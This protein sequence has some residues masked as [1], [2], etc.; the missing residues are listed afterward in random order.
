MKAPFEPFS[1]KWRRIVMTAKP[2]VRESGHRKAASEFA[3][4]EARLRAEKNATALQG[5][6]GKIYRKK[7]DFCQIAKASGKVL[8]KRSADKPLIK[9]QII[10]LLSGGIVFALQGS[11][12]SVR[13]VWKR[14]WTYS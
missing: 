9:R 1:G 3:R 5:R 7:G 12:Q 2:N 8:I 11:V 10:D 4:R 14:N 13:D 6:S